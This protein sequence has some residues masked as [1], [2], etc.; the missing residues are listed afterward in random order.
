M[1]HGWPAGTGSP[2]ILLLL[3]DDSLLARHH[4]KSKLFVYDELCWA[5]F[6]E[7]ELILSVI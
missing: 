1:V 5:N 6:R 4:I 3:F 2:Q 7:D